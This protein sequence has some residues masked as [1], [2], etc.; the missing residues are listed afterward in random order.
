MPAPT[1]SWPRTVSGRSCAQVTRERG[2]YLIADEVMSGFGRCGEWFAWQ[3][4]GDANR[5]DLMSLAKGLTGG[6]MPLAAV[7]LAAGVSAKLDSQMLYTGLTYCGHPLACAAGV[8]AVRAYEEG[9]LIERSRRLGAQLFG[10]LSSCSSATRVIGDVR[11][12][13][14]L[15][16]VLELV[17]DRATRAPLSP[18][19]Q[20]HPGLRQPGG[21]GAAQQGVSFAA[22]GNLLLLA[23][24]LVIAENELARCARA[25][26]PAARRTG[27]G[28]ELQADLRDDVQPAAAQMHERFEAAA[29]ATRAGAGRAARPLHRRP[30]R[31]RAQR[32]SSRRPR[33]MAAALGHFPAADAAEV[34]CA[35]AAAKRAF[36]PWRATPVGGAGPPDE[37]GGR[38]HRGACLPDR[39]RA[40][41]SRSARTA[42]RAWGRRRR[43]RTSSGP[44]PQDFERNSGYARALADDPLTDYRSHNRSVLKPHGVWAVIAPFNFPLALLGGPTAAALVTGNTVVAKGATDTPWA[45]RLL[46]DCIRDAGV[47]AGV[48]NY[49]TGTGSLA[50]ERLVSHADVAGIT[51]TGSHAVGMRICRS[52]V[53][54]P[55]R[56]RASPRWAARM[57]PS[58]PRHAD[59]ERAVP[60]IVRSAF[61]LSGQKCSAL[62]RVYVEEAVAR[63][64]L[65]RLRTAIAR[66]SASAIRCVRENWLGPV[67]STAAAEKFAGY[68]ARLSSRRRTASSPAATRLT[69]CLRT[70]ATLREPDAWPRHP[71]THPL[72]AEEMF[73]PI[74]MVCRVPD[75]DR[76]LKLANDSPLGLTAGMYGNEAEVRQFLDADRGGSHLREPP[77]GSDHRAHGPGTRP[78]AAGRAP[79]PPARRSDPSTTCRSTCASSRRRSSSTDAARARCARRSAATSATGRRLRSRASRT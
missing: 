48:F 21:E 39:R 44:M 12:G 26:G 18:W 29:A 6:H 32:T 20:E 27:T 60:G 51:F 67:I 62:S 43:R 55:V 46:A 78:S 57:P 9:A 40:C 42:W 50:G 23:P 11:G 5:P 72:F 25:A 69:R 63:Q 65:E 4:Y 77:A 19:P 53:S 70:R 56:D 8:A 33:W 71:P 58:S 47:P 66:A 45:G 28:H 2:V 52:M 22:R 24:P 3:R 34:D 17:R 16:A 59:L 49:L 75:L 38:T 41:A 15:F 36:P 31:H 37:G 14:G 35:V 10:E 7:V 13:H 54:G 76:A 73:L 79:V 74:L 30:R 64:L 61:G 68:C 1:A